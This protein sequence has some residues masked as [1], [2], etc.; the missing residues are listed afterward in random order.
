MRV[1]PFILGSL[2]LAACA[3]HHPASTDG[4]LAAASASGAPA[5]A[6]PGVSPSLASGAP[7]PVIPVTGGPM[8]VALPLG[9]SLFLP[10]N[11]GPPVTAIQTQ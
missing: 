9:G 8:L 5:A 6:G 7:R 10:L 11:D 3:T 2:A 4:P 1:L